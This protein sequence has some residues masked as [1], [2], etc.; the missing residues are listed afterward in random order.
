MREAHLETERR[1]GRGRR[2]TAKGCDVGDGDR[3]RAW[4]RYVHRTY[5]SSSQARIVL[6]EVGRRA[7]KNDGAAAI[8]S[9][10][11]VTDVTGVPKSYVEKVLREAQRAGVLVRTERGHRRWDGVARASVFSL[12]IPQPA[13]PCATGRV[14]GDAQPAE[15][16]PP[17]RDDSTA[18]PDLSAPTTRP[19][20]TY[21]PTSAGADQPTGGYPGHSPTGTP[22]E[23][24]PAE[25]LPPGCDHSRTP[26]PCKPCRRG[27]PA[28]D[29]IREQRRDAA[30]AAGRLNELRQQSRP[31]EATP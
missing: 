27:R 14:D 2:G 30:A 23:G 29:V 17:G 21:N 26:F 12:S 7:G 18:Q 1:P 31:A 8:A 16:R 19:L 9:V 24:E 10:A 28:L 25:P 11:D 5:R 22:L 3:R 15:S 13:E 20:G 6:A 4:L